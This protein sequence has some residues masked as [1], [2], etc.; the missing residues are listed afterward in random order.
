MSVANSV[1]RHAEYTK[2]QKMTSTVFKKLE[3]DYYRK[4]TDVFNRPAINKWSI[5]EFIR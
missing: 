2:I 3:I 5:H 1:P 4:D